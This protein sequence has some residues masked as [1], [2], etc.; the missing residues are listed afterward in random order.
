MP[1]SPKRIETLVGLFLF[2]G[3]ALLGTLILQ[4]GRFSD[5][6]RGGYNLTAFFTDASEVI[7]GSEVRL[8]GAKIGRVV[9]RPELTTNEK[10]KGKVGVKLVIWDDAPPLDRNS[11]FQIKSVNFLGDMVITVTPPRPPDEE[12]GQNFKDGDEVAGGGPSGLEALQS[13]AQHIAE[14]A[15]ELMARGGDTLS[16]IDNALDELR[17]VTGQLTE[18]IDRVNSGL[19]AD[20]NMENF[21][22][23]L[24]DLRGATANIKDASLEIKP[25]IANAQGAVNSFDRAA[26]EAQGTFAQASSEISKLGP[27]LEKVPRAVDSIAQ[28]ADDASETLKNVK[29]SDGLLGTLAYDREVKDDA[30]TFLKNLRHYGI[31]R[32]RDAE[33]FDER[34]P[35][36][37]FRGRRR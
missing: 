6:F 34:D 11:V 10:W 15:R 9:E 4:F 18:S 20:E 3:L 31:L 8:A 7:K 22:G 21:R 28:V 30:K 33:T 14:D 35:R 32:Y 1:Q 13:D 36:N 37:R 2:L 27:A 25:L 12:D 16:K 29:N 24:V 23:A 26:E 5:S 19:L 17:F